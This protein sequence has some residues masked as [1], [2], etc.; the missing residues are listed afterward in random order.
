[1][2]TIDQI[3]KLLN[4]PLLP[5]EDAEKI[6]DGFRFLAE[7]VFEKLQTERKQKAVSANAVLNCTSN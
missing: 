6:R 1:M 3:K 2:L 5:D 7:I 4:D